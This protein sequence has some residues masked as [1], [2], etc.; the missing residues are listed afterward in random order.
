MPSRISTT[1]IYD[2]KKSSMGSAPCARP[3][4]Y[5]LQPRKCLDCFFKIMRLDYRFAFLSASLAVHTHL[6]VF[7]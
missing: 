5:F 4:K 6:E 7:S 3:Y 1:W 2:M